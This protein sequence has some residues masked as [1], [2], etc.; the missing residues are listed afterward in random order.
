MLFSIEIHCHFV[1]IVFFYTFKQI[2]IAWIKKMWV[3]N[4]KL[5][6]FNFLLFLFYLFSTSFLSL[7]LSVQAFD[8]SSK[9]KK[10]TLKMYANFVQC[11]R[12]NDTFSTILT[13]GYVSLIIVRDFRSGCDQS[14]QMGRKK[15]N[16]KK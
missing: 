13:K 15:N 10:M 16:E 6:Q 7:F 3:A 12:F 9:R 4:G 14:V 5:F 8:E 2:Q 11:K 1:E